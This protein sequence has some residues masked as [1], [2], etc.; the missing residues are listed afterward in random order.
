MS[1]PSHR[2][3]LCI[4][5]LLLIGSTIITIFILLEYIQQKN[6][7]WHGIAENFAFRSST[8]YLVS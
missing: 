5:T 4:F 8:Q 1:I 7:T 3:R 6:E 2:N